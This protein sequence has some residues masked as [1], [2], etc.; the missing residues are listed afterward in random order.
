MINRP[1]SRK[2]ET[3]GLRKVGL[4][5]AWMYLVIFIL[6]FGVFVNVQA[7]V[8]ERPAREKRQRREAAMEQV[9]NTT[10]ALACIMC[11]AVPNLRDHGCVA[12]WDIA[13][14]SLPRSQYRANGFA[15]WGW[16]AQVFVGNASRAEARCKHRHQDRL[17]AERCAMQMLRRQQVSERTSTI[18]G[19]PRSAWFAMVAEHGYRCFY[20]RERFTF[21]KLEREHKT[22]IARGGANRSSNI[23]PS[24]KP[25][26]R[27]KG[28]QTAEEFR[29]VLDA[30]SG[31]V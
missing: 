3:G 17:A 31:S 1:T 2:L 18:E 21:D 25:C 9:A 14:I 5:E 15:A 11:G 13:E 27:R 12:R 10:S 22:P 19:L 24:C 29:A 28:T 26:N 20:C 6:G 8:R 23:V 4:V 16:A 30:E 7:H